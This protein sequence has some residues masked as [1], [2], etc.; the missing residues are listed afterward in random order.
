LA[1]FVKQLVSI[2]ASRAGVKRSAL[3][4][5]W[6]ITPC[7]QGSL[8]RTFR[9][10]FERQLGES[11]SVETGEELV[12][13]IVVDSYEVALGWIGATMHF[14]VELIEGGFSL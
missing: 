2:F 7:T 10:R 12:E 1:Y 13:L 6:P 8:A 3:V 4:T 14:G 5:A 9:Y 11:E